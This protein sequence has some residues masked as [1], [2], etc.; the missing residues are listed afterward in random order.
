M[1][2]PLIPLFVE[3]GITLAVSD[4]SLT[5]AT[6][7]YAIA[8]AIS[9]RNKLFFGCG[10]FIT[11]LQSIAFGWLQSANNALSSNLRTATLG[12]IGF[13]F[14]FHVLERYNRHVVDGIPFLDFNGAAVGG[15]P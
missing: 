3:Y 15:K 13:V 5:L 7:M 4:R 8:I 1:L 11:I 10:I 9:S 14:L 2:L 12:C 6:S